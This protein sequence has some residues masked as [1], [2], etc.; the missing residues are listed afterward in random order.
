M[1]IKVIIP[2]EGDRTE[3]TLSWVHL[4]VHILMEVLHD[5]THS[6]SFILGTRQMLFLI[7]YLLS[8]SLRSPCTCGARHALL[9]AV[10]GLHWTQKYQFPRGLFYDA[11]SILI[12]SQYFLLSFTP[13]LGEGVLFLL[14]SGSYAQTKAK[15]VSIDNLLMPNY[16]LPFLIF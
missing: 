7:G 15:V 5:C 9:Y 14:Q 16:R 2:S 8:I 13:F 4:Y 11:P 6:S 1:N 10:Q 12:L 3:I